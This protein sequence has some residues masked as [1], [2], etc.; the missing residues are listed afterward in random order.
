MTNKPGFYELVFLFILLSACGRVENDVTHYEEETEAVPTI[1]SAPQPE[2][3]SLGEF[4]R[5]D[6][7]TRLQSKLDNKEDLWVHVLVPLCD[8]EHQGIVPVSQS[9]GDGSN[10]KSNLYWGALYGVKTHLKKHKDWTLVESIQQPNMDDVILERVVFRKETDGQSIYIVADAYRGDQMKDCLSDYLNALAGKSKASLHV[11][12]TD[13]GILGNADLIVFNGHNGLM[14]VEMDIIPNQDDSYRDAMAIACASH[15]YF[16]GHLEYTG[17]YPLLMT[18]NLLAPEAY[19][20]E[21]VISTW[22][23]G[24]DGKS[25]ADAAGKAYHEYQNCGYKGARRLFTTGW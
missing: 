24:K 11:H 2:P 16:T 10:P 1:I 5:E 14:D 3:E 21:N 22:A 13:I 9:L 18:T 20:L 25:I 15:G 7:L 8:N 23:E 19:V 12:D 17:G 6:I 4:S